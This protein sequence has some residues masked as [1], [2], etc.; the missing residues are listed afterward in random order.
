MAGV[1]DVQLQNRQKVC[2][3][4]LLVFIETLVVYGRQHNKKYKPIEHAHIGFI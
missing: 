2:L 1:V 3:T 4:C